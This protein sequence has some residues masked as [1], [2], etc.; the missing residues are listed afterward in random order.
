VEKESFLRWA[1]AG[2]WL[3]VFEHDA[4]TPAATIAQT[5]GGNFTAVP[6]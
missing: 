2:G 3:V 4:E 1:Q 5:A 6:Q